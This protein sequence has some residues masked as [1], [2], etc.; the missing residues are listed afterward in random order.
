MTAAPAELVE[1]IR[2]ALRGVI[3]PELGDNIVDLGLVYGV[4][5]E[6][7]ALARIEMTTTTP[8]CPATGYL[9][10]GARQSA[11]RV[12]GVE[13][14]EVTLTYEPPWTPQMMSDEAKLRLGVA[15]GGGW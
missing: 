11:S 12:P 10:E 3:D 14:V 2:E 6:A 8:G 1:R 13:E 4:A 5:V 7:G 15:D 9:T